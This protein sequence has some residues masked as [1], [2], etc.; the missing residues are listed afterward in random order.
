MA[1]VLVRIQYSFDLSIISILFVAQLLRTRIGCQSDCF[2]EVSLESFRVP[3]IPAATTFLDKLR[4]FPCNSEID[5]RVL[6]SPITT[7]FLLISNCHLVLQEM[8]PT[9]YISRPWQQA[10]VTDQGMA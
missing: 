2:G 7:S 6:F 10:V 8:S 1:I 3:K 4:A 5:L 9:T